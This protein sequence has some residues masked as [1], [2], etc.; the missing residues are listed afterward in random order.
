MNDDRFVIEDLRRTNNDL[1]MKVRQ[2]EVDLSKA[3]SKENAAYAQLDIANELCMDLQKEL[4]EAKGT[5]G[6]REAQLGTVY[7]QLEQSERARTT[8][9]LMLQA[10]D[11]V[12]EDLKATENKL[13]GKLEEALKDASRWC[14]VAIRRKK[15]LLEAC[16]VIDDAPVLDNDQTKDLSRRG[17]SIEWRKQAYD[18]DAREMAS[19]LVAQVCRPPM[20]CYTCEQHNEELVDLINLMY[21]LC[22]AASVEAERI[23]TGQVWKSI[24]NPADTFI[25]EAKK[26]QA[27]LSRLEEPLKGLFATVTTRGPW[28][29]MSEED[30]IKLLESMKSGQE[31]NPGNPLDTP[32]VQLTAE[33]YESP[34]A[35]WNGEDRRKIDEDILLYGTGFG[36]HRP[37]GRIEHIPAN[38]VV[39]E[40]RAPSG[41]IA[42]AWGEPIIPLG[43][44]VSWRNAEMIDLS[45]QTGT[46]HLAKDSIVDGE[47]LNA[48]MERGGKIVNDGFQLF[49]MGVDPGKPDKEK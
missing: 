24:G 33:S 28:D 6:T 32:A 5:I 34:L 45:G 49:T 41:A 14:D 2:L 25:N 29:P 27:R 4:D 44:P 26:Y 19:W 47:S 37:D 43:A 1:E 12:L 46:I 36:R 3:H 23:T 20:Q 31:P 7:A 18:R 16:S 39:M 11:K 40:H 10:Q 30:H 22:L 8:G 21:P 38:E 42:R 9:V 17:L 35:M 15:M 13:R 48:F